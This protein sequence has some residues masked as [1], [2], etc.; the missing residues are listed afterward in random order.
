MRIL[1][2]ATLINPSGARDHGLVNI[3]HDAVFKGNH[4]RD[5][6]HHRTRLIAQNGMVAPFG[7]IAGNLVACQVADSLNLARGHLHKHASAPLGLGFAAHVVE[8]GF[9]NVLQG[10]IDGCGDVISRHG[11]HLLH[12]ND[13]VIELQAMCL[14]R[15]AIEQRVECFFKAGAAAH[16]GVIYRFGH[17]VKPCF[18]HAAYAAR[19]HRPVGFAALHFTLI[20]QAIFILGQLKEGERFEPHPFAMSEL[21]AQQAVTVAFFVVIG[22][23]QLGSPL[24]G[25]ARRLKNRHRVAQ[26]GQRSHENRVVDARRF[27]IDSHGVVMQIGGQLGDVVGKEFSSFRLHFCHFVDNAVGLSIPATGLH[28]CGLEHAEDDGAGKHE[29]EKHHQRVAQQDEFFV[30]FFHFIRR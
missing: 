10:H 29:H 5:G 27:S 19:S 17:R 30:G 23:E 16:I 11:R 22:I 7:I 2:G 9:H 26:S 28:H 13:A 21:A 1:D 25:R 15:N 4:H 18:G 8:L 3:F 12:G 20:I 6:F 14:T 24:L